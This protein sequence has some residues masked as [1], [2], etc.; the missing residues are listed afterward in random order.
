MVLGS[1]LVEILTFNNFAVQWF[2][3]GTEA[4]RYLSKYTCDAIISDLMMPTMNGEDFFLKIHKDLKSNS[5]PFIVI[6]AKMDN[7]SKYRLLEQGANDYI[8]KPFK[9]AELIYKIRNILNFKLN[10]IRKWSP[11]PFSRV[12]INVSERD[13]ITSV[14]EILMENLKSKINHTA[15]AKT[16]FISKSTL[17]N[18]IR[19]HT[20][21]NISQYIREFKLNHTL[22]LIHLGEKNIQSLV[23]ES[24][25][26][27]FSY[28]NSSFK[29][30]VGMSARDY[31]K[32]QN[33]KGEF[34]IQSGTKKRREIAD[35]F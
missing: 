1:S 29:S 19:K 15:L 14:N 7:E 9:I 10:V 27:S 18:R 35:L 20:S 5:T 22:K 24:G 4:F 23:N 34:K 17:D 28:F 2:K 31:I 6:T 33:S 8:M 32:N 12:T 3:D 11:D 25:F 13:F 21:K 26:N 16:L 30:F